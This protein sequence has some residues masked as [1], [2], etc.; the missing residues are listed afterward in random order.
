[1]EATIEI[2]NLHKRFGATV[3]LDGM[4]FTVAP[5]EVTGFVG[6]NGVGKSTTMRVILGLDAPDAGSV[7]I[8]GQR[9]TSPR[10][11]VNHAGS[12]LD[13]PV[14][15]P[16][17]SARN[18]SGQ[19]KPAHADRTPGAGRPRGCTSADAARESPGFGQP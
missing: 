2:S 10:H 19:L 9:Y 3:A 4:T 8:G 1:M 15:Q 11:P 17:R 18:R 14:L 12:L 5:G 6:P 16:S 7:L 13:A